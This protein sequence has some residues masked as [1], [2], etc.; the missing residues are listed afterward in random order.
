[1][2]APTPAEIE[3]EI[4]RTRAELQLTVDQLSQRLDPRTQ[5][6]HAVDEAKIAIAD[7]KRRVTGEVPGPDQAQATRT[8]WIV[9]GAGA[10]LAA[11]VVTTVIRKL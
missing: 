2:S 5:A 1:M 3:A 7:L 11:A 6:R 9:L 4:A 8:G 10:A